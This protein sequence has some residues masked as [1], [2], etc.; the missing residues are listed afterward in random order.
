MDIRTGKTYETFEAA[1]K[2]GVPESDIAQLQF[3]EQRSMNPTFM[4]PPKV[5][6]TKGSFKRVPELVK[7]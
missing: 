2:A 6:F 4:P 5:K 3:D 1:R 7:D